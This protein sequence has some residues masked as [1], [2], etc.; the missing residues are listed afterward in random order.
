MTRDARNAATAK[1][2]GKKGG[3]PT[4]SNNSGN[5]NWDKGSVKAGDN[6]HKPR[7]KSQFEKSMD[8][9]QGACAQKKSTRQTI[10]EV[11]NDA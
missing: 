4:L 7:A 8:F 6:P 9:S 2:N 1:K 3:N 10:L 5:S 11:F